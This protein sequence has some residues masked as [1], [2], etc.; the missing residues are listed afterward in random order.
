MDPFEWENQANEHPDLV[1]ELTT[2]IEHWWDK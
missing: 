2:R 1:E